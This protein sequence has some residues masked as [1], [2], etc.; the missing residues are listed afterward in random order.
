MVCIWNRLREDKT[1]VGASCFL[2]GSSGVTSR[3]STGVGNGR[4][5]PD[6]VFLSSKVIVYIQMETL[7][8]QLET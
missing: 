4:L 2:L 7:K 3:G 6:L 1:P 5:S 8:K